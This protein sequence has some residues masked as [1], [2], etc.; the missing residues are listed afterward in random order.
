MNFLISLA[1]SINGSLRK[2]LNRILFNILHVFSPNPKPIMIIPN[3]H[4][5][6][7]IDGPS[8]TASGGPWPNDAGSLGENTIAIGVTMPP[9]RK[10]NPMI[11]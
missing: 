5:M 8:E 4:T 6:A 3:M 7:P 11:I 10:M 2:A 1:P 9:T